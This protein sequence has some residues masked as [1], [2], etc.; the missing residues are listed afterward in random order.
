MKSNEIPSGARSLVNVVTDFL[1][2]LY[3]RIARR[4]GTKSL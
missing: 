3:R 2:T 1:Y 4:L